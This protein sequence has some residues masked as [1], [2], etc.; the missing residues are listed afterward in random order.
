MNEV[1]GTN[2]S[3]ASQ[4][5]E[6]SQTS[7]RNIFERILVPTDGSEASQRAILAGA[8]FARELGAEIV[9]FIATP[10]FRVLSANPDVLADT[11]EQYAV[12]SSERA[13]RLLADI[14]Q[15]ARAAGVPCR[16]EHAVSDNPHE[17]I[18]DAAGRFN[19]DLILMASHGRHG[20][21]GLLLG[22]ETQ[23][24]LVHSKLPVLVHR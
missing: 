14:G 2:A 22:S 16:L 13:E 8:D 17:A 1:Q 20:I 4:A 3:Q 6:A 21:A 15:A 24:V 9:G 12:G 10:E 18:I 11:P 23:K 5:S 19:C 7:R